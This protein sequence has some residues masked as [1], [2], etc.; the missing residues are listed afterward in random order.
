[1]RRFRMQSNKIAPDP[2]EGSNGGFAI[3][4]SKLLTD[5]ES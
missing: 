4:I 3:T 2:Q 5:S 1:M